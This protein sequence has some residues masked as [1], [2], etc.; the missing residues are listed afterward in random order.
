M[1]E[2][3]QK[4]MKFS[5]L[6]FVSALGKENQLSAAAHLIGISQ[7]AAS[8]LAA[9]IEAIIGIKPFRRVGRGIELTPA[10]RAL[11]ERADRILREME[12]ASLRS[13]RPLR[14]STGPSRQ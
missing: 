1:V 14:A 10:G 7:P 6:R 2:L 13:R 5:H 11:A 9:E 3:V 4:G 8:R 12:R